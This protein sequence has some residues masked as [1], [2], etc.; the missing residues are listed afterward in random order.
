MPKP[1]SVGQS[2]PMQQL[3]TEIQ[4]LTFSEFIE[5]KP[6]GSHYELYDGVP[7]EMPQPPGNHE[8]IKGFLI[9]Q[10][11]LEYTRLNLPYIVPNQ[12]F[13][14]KPDAE[15]AYLPDVLVLNRPNL[16]H[17]PLWAKA[18]TVTLGASIPLIIEVVSN[19]WRVDYLTKLKDY[20]EMGI[21]EY[22]LVDY[23]GLGGRRFLGNPKQPTIFIH[24]F[25]DGEYQV[26]AFREQE[27]LISPTF[28]ELLL[29]VA[30]VFQ[31]GSD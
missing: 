27:R 12:V 31:A 17:E 22:W 9:N 6:D 1:L 3:K 2:P 25:I 16:I 23:L 13:V 21:R 14:K 5:W 24:E 19:N 20:E 29:T 28:P 30:Q 4:R 7:I 18:S 26:S 11:V 8:A 10:I 15:S